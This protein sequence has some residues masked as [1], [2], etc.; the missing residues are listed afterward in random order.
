MVDLSGPQAYVAVFDGH[1]GRRCA[2]YAGAHLHRT[3][4]GLEEFAKKDYAAAFRQAYLK[5][6]G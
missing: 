6:S 4:F 3:L 1:A 5:V 2:D